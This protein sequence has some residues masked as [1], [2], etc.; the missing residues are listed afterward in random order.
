MT[1]Y[2]CRL[3]RC[4]RRLHFLALASPPAANRRQADPFARSA[5]SATRVSC[6]HCH[7][8]FFRDLRYHSG[9][10]RRLSGQGGAHLRILFRRRPRSPLRDRRRN[11]APGFMSTPVDGWSRSSTFWFGTTPAKARSSVAGLMPSRR[12]SARR[13]SQ[14]S[15]KPLPGSAKL[16][17]YRLA[18]EG[19]AGI[20]LARKFGGSA[21]RASTPA[22]AGAI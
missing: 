17:A 11:S 9:A 13:H 22:R 15:A 7:R 5:W 18:T 16:W 3:I 4:N 20:A 10:L 2:H 6:G 14:K 21:W 1:A 8:H 19:T 12:V